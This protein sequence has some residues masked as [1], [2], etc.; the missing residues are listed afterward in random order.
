MDLEAM[1]KKLMEGES[2]EALRKLA[3]SD[4][5]AEL[6]A[7][8]G[9]RDAEEAVRQR[10]E[11]RMRAILQSVISTPEGRELAARVREAMNGHGK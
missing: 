3:A 8:F 11:A 10:D 2:G 9:G 7:R 5:G 4:A 1:A 6:S